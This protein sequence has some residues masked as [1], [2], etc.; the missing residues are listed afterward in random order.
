MKK[1]EI[2]MIAMVA[3][4][5]MKL[6]GNV[7]FKYW[8]ARTIKTLAP[9]AGPFIELRDAIQKEFDE[10]RIEICEK[11][12]TKDENG[13]S[14]I[15]DNKFVGLDNNDEY[16]NAY[17]DLVK[18]YDPKLIELNSILSEDEDIDF[19]KINIENIPEGITGEQ[20]IILE[21]LI[22]FE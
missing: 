16:K 4:Q 11:Y 1:N 13:E 22:K 20:M 21:S 6:E 18:S 19:M 17:S 15:E 7:K 5:L 12:C 3:D 14:I 9:I 2:V 8:L 10:K